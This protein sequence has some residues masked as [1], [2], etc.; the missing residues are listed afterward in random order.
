MDQNIARSKHHIKYYYKKTL[1][2][3]TKFWRYILEHFKILEQFGT[4]NK[5]VQHQ[6]VK[7]SNRKR[8]KYSLLCSYRA[9]YIY[10]P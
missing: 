3:A 2:T 1:T 10:A 5:S 6:G 9:L 8:R 4:Q 7:N